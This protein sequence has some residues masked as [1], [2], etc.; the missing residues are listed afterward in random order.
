MNCTHFILFVLCICC[1][2]LIG[3]RTSVKTGV[4]VDMSDSHNITAGFHEM[5]S[6][7]GFVQPKP[8]GKLGEREDIV[9]TFFGT[10]ILSRYIGHC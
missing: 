6:R 5:Y 8:I 3:K 2:G 4:Y 9:G 10:T 1:R 7:H